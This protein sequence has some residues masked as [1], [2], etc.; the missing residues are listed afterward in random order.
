M[1]MQLPALNKQAASAN[2]ISISNSCS[3]TSLI[4]SSGLSYFWLQDGCFFAVKKN[5][6]LSCSQEGYTL[7]WERET[8]TS[9]LQK[10]EIVRYLQ[11]YL[12]RG[13]LTVSHASEN[14]I[15]W[16]FMSFLI[17]L[18]R[19][20]MFRESLSLRHSS[21]AWSIQYIKVIYFGVS[22]SN[23][24][25]KQGLKQLSSLVSLLCQRTYLCVPTL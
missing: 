21:S 19:W 22:F 10:K 2:N 6:L 8:S 16:V 17:V 24:L 23:S 7:V 1:W 4:T 20:G 13:L 15:M 11:S 18:G 5:V 9:L 3:S 25:I 12:S 14:T